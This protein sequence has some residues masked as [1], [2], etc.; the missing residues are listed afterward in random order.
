VTGRGDDGGDIEAM[1]A[2]DGSVVRLGGPDVAVDES[3]IPE[4]FTGVIVPTSGSTGTPKA[5][6]LSR[7]ALIVAAD[8]V[9]ARLGGPG[10]WVNPLPGWYVAGLMTRVRA[11]V[12][13][14]AH[15]QISPHLEDLPRPGSRS[16]ISLVPA[17]LHRALSDPALAERL[18]GYEAVLIGGSALGH[19]LRDQA[20]RAGV[21]VVTTYGM[22]ETCGGVVYD[23]TPLDG[24]HVEIA[25]PVDEIGRVLLTTPTLFEGYLGDPVHTALVR[26][27]GSLWTFDRGRLVG[28]R[29][30]ILGRV[31]DVVQS[32]G[33]NVDLAQ[34]QRLLDARFP[35]QTAC[36]AVPDPVWGSTVIVASTGPGRDVVLDVLA[37]HITSAARPRGFLR[38]DAVPLST[39][40]KIDRA[41]LVE[42]WRQ[43]GDRA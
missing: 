39:S 24:V 7:A 23:G 19:A 36:F 20:E 10:V 5:V 13:G 34:M 31:D 25:D 2:G 40:G 27:D 29:L 1:L 15:H 16:Y 6:M 14:T 9:H 8:A 38:V 4:G 3:A 30:E 33:T 42:K 26:R 41:S 18:A 22:S 28:S 43:D 35:H 17:H 37:P 12:A 21:R 11:L 32:G